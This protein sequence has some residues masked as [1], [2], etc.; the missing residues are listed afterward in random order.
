MTF[1][2]NEEERKTKPKKKKRNQN[3]FGNPIKE[4]EGVMKRIT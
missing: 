2:R 4:Y 1:K 3:K